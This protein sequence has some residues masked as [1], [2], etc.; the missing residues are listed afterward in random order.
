MVNLVLW[1]LY[2]DVL[3]TDPVARMNAQ[4]QTRARVK[5]ISLA[6]AT[7]ASLCSIKAIPHSFTRGRVKISYLHVFKVL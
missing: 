7:G 1:E 4:M 3:P 6:S 2:S 5:G